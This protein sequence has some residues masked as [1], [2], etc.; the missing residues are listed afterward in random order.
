[1]QLHWGGGWGGGAPGAAAGGDLERQHREGGVAD[2]REGRRDAVAAGMKEALLLVLVRVVLVRG[3][4]GVG[5]EAA[6][7]GTR[8]A[9]LNPASSGSVV[10]QPCTQWLLHG[11]SVAL[12]HMC[13]C[14]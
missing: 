11:C 8:S 2:G 9:S 6:C 14:G 12:M 7:S 4:H 1:M 13:S 5:V 3:V 10:Q